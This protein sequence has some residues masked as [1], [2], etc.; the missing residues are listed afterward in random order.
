MKQILVK[1]T[2]ETTD[3]LKQ[4][5]LSS[6]NFTK[7]V[8]APLVNETVNVSMSKNIYQVSLSMTNSV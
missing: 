5:C 3:A 4:F 1:G 8:L 7:D 6:A 2:D